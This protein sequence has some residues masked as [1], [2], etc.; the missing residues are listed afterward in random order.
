MN[1]ALKRAD[2]SNTFTQKS[3]DS[4]ISFN[5]RS[6]AIAKVFSVFAKR[7]FDFT[8]KQTSF[9]NAVS[10]SSIS[11]AKRTLK[12]FNKTTM[13]SSNAPYIAFAIKI[14]SF[15]IGKKIRITVYLGNVGKTPARN[16]K[17]LIVLA[18]NQSFREMDSI[19]GNPTFATGIIYPSILN[20]PIFIRS[21]YI[22]DASRYDMIKSGKVI[23]TVRALFN[24]TT[25]LMFFIL[26]NFMQSLIPITW[27]S[28]M[29]IKEMN[30]KKY[31]INNLWFVKYIISKI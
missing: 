27:I 22:L 8:T 21:S 31:F 29:K 11:I 12:Y 4:S 20:I 23:E 2:V 16:I 1:E 13:I 6:L 7:N 17:S 18:Y 25:F 14:D 19:P 15:A 24:I 26:K 5:Q 10:E 3:V 30:I 9:S 28:F